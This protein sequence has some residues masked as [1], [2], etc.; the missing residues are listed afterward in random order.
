MS[1]Y[2]MLAK[3]RTAPDPSA[4]ASEPALSLLKW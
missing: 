2:S 1:Y 3:L 4:A